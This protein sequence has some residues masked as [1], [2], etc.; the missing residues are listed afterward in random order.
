MGNER[1]LANIPSG[2]ATDA[3]EPIR[4]RLQ[5]L[6]GP[7]QVMVVGALAVL[8]S[9]DFSFD[10]ASVTDLY[11][12]LRLP[13]PANVSTSL[14]R[15]EEQRRL[16]RGPA[17]RWTLTPEGE[18]YVKTCAASVPA[19]TLAAEL[20]P[21]PSA[22]LGERRHAL[23]PP[24]FAPSG[25]EQGLQRLLSS[26]SFE[27]NVMLITKF[28]ADDDDPRTEVVTLLRNACTSHGLNLLLASDG[29]TED[30]LWANV[31]TYMW[32]SQYG[33]VII[34]SAD[35]ALNSNVLIE[36]GGMLMTGRR[37]AIL[38]DK[39]VPSMPT[40][41]V[42]HIYKP[43]DLGEPR[44]VADAVH[45]WLRDDLGQPGCGTCPA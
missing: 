28:P 5:R 38:R 29:N 26:G 22:N 20:G 2:E 16:L 8:H 14:R 19:S 17:G 24:L 15:H 9:E 45:R 39:S 13:P 25:V 35:G 42:G 44:A 11:R 3:Q 12:R 21:A 40:D 36:L 6:P 34:D 41:L 18:H 10:S 30:T 7:A 32:G 37:C 27:T 33:I 23:I 4:L 43:V 31:V 1:T